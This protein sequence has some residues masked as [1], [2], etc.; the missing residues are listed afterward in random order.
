MFKI[1]EINFEKIRSMVDAADHLD[2]SDNTDEAKAILV[3]LANF[4]LG[5]ENG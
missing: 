2:Q 1:K 5:A 4:I 3:K